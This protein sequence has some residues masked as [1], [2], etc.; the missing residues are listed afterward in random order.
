M[1]RVVFWLNT[2]STFSS[3]RS[4]LLPATS[5]ACDSSRSVRLS[6]GVRLPS[7]TWPFS[8]KLPRP[9]T[10]MSAVLTEVT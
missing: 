5:I 10:K 2:F 6:I 7:V 4:R 9:S 1:W 8:K 3:N